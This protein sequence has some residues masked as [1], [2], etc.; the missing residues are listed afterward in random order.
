MTKFPNNPEQRQFNKKEVAYA[1]APAGSPRRCGGCRHFGIDG[2][3]FLVAGPIDKNDTCTQWFEPTPEAGGKNPL[4]E[5]DI[6]ETL[7]MLLGRT[8]ELPSDLEFQDGSG[9]G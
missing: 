2:S 8:G 4:D 6:K 5:L 7:N 9:H 3:C 1:E